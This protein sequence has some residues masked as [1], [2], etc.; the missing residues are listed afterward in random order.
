MARATQIEDRS[1]LPDF[2]RPLPPAGGGEIIQDLGLVISSG[3]KGTQE[4]LLVLCNLN[5]SVVGPYLRGS[6][7]SL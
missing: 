1:P 7:T 6:I 4:A 2:Q 5:D 3:E